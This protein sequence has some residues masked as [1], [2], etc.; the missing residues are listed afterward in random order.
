MCI[1]HFVYLASPSYAKF[2]SSVPHWHCTCM[3]IKYFIYCG[4]LSIL[5]TCDTWLF[6]AKGVVV[7][8]LNLCTASCR[9]WHNVSLQWCGS[10]VWEFICGPTSSIES[11]NWG[12]VYEISVCNNVS[13]HWL[14]CSLCAL[15]NLFNV[16]LQGWTW[17]CV[18]GK[19]FLCLEIQ[20]LSIYTCA[21][22][23]IYCSMLHNLIATG[24]M[25]P[26]PWWSEPY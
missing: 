23:I 1:S 10:G 16:S 15:H 24:S 13:L 17:D 6:A 7:R 5:L 11:P 14:S 2:T 22:V 4:W 20:V 25:L 9:I 19:I 12:S 8:W 21:F 26:T 18:K 3:C